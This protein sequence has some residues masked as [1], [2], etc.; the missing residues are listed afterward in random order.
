VRMND[1]NAGHDGDSAR[2]TP[3]RAGWQRGMVPDLDAPWLDIAEDRLRDLLDFQQAALPPA[4]AELL[5][6]AACPKRATPM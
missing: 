2:F 5:D 3:G 1:N 4:L 6:P